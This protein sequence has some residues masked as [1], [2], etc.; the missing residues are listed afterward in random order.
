MWRMDDCA[1]GHYS[2]ED[3]HSA[4][5]QQ[6]NIV[7]FSGP[8][9][10]YADIQ[11]AHQLVWENT[12]GRQTDGVLTLCS[13]LGDPFYK[14]VARAVKLWKEYPGTVFNFHMEKGERCFIERKTREAK[15]SHYP[16]LIPVEEGRTQGLVDL[17]RGSQKAGGLFVEERFA[18]Q[19]P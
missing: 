11:D 14:L 19:R 16:S 7:I 10:G 1:G 3:F 2:C 8:N 13:E 6:H 12:C 4:I 15:Q 9:D 18:L 5:L 17:T